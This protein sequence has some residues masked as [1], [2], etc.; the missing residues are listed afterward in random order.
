MS[1]L[2][3]SSPNKCTLFY[4]VQLIFAWQHSVNKAIPCQMVN[5]FPF[6]HHLWILPEKQQTTISGYW[7]RQAP[8]GSLTISVSCQCEMQLQNE[9]SIRSLGAIS[10]QSK[11]H[12][13]L[14]WSLWAGGRSLITWYKVE[15]FWNVRTKEEFGGFVFF[16]VVVLS[17][18][19]MY[20][21]MRRQQSLI[22]LA[23][24]FICTFLL[25]C[26][27]DFCWLMVMKVPVWLIR[28]H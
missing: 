21:V 20:T 24:I 1:Q 5:F 2:F 19:V 16:V 8:Q 27:C 15:L 7:L 23:L 6:A 17:S 28:T 18:W 10:K 12:R 3:I 26:C 25:A 13:V 11:V 22:V 9:K 4:T 14:L